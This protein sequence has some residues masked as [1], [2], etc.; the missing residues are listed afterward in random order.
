MSKADLQAKVQEL[1]ISTKNDEGKDLKVDE[2]KAIIANHGL[3]GEPDPAE[4]ADSPEPLETTDEAKGAEVNPEEVDPNQVDLEEAIEEAEEE[5]EEEEEPG[6]TEEPVAEAKPEEEAPKPRKSAPPVGYRDK[7]KLGVLKINKFL[8]NRG[9][10]EE[11]IRE[12]LKEL[13][14]A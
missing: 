10:T 9:G 2:L 4:P 8:N 14:E 3:G 12:F 11:E 6:E 5:E 7:L 1:G 13:S